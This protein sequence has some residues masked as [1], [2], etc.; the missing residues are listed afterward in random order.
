MGESAS[1]YDSEVSG[2]VR[3]GDHVVSSPGTAQQLHALL[4]DTLGAF[5]WRIRV[6]DW[7]G[8]EYS[9]GRC[10]PHWRGLPLDVHIRSKAAGQDLL[11]LNA[12]AFLDRFVQGEVDLRG[13]LYLLSD[14]RNHAEL[15]VPLWKLLPRLLRSRAL[16]FQG[17]SRARLNVKSHYDI[18]QEALNIY[19]D[20]VY[21]SYSCGMFERP[22][23]LDVEE[24]TQEGHGWGDTHD[25]LEKA[26]WRK[27]KDAVDFVDPRDG[28]TLLDVGCGYGGQ[29]LVGLEH[30][31]FGK[32][33][34]W[35]H[36][37]NQVVEG[38]KKLA[39]YP[40]DRWE[41]REG[42]FRQEVRVFGHVTSTGMISHVGPRGL[43]PYVR[44][45]RRL[46]KSTGRYVHHALMTPHTGRVLDSDVG[47]AFN[48]KYVWPGFHWFT[49]GAHVKALEENGFEVAKLVNL[50][51]HY[52]KTT[53]AWYER[54][55]QHQE[56]MVQ[57]L[58]EATFRA[59]Q[60]YLAGSS[61]GFLNGTM[62]VY[63]V[64]CRAV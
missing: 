2:N 21:R 35:T 14:I 39:R 29:L 44:N 38:V 17:V 34:G 6:S 10:E 41:L 3:S 1:R 62:Q 28:E 40:A 52:G 15:S 33:V 30:Y 24:L 26:Q 42:D 48:K 20:K 36:S 57:N 9:L 45:V 37:S 46:I 27:F 58:G 47:I 53:A 49:L 16:L 19:L 60:I 11:S 56:T 18:S 50:S 55:M 22:D 59:W 61:A 12:L 31:P 25:S 8:Q 13:N 4:R 51:P 64:Y 63:R 43:I 23:H 7:T 5:P 54:M 32:V